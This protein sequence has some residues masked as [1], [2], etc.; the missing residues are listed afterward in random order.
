MIKF[1]RKI[2]QKLLSE[3]NTGKY[4]KYAIGEIVLVMVGILLALKVNN[5]N[6]NR[7]L[8]NTINNLYSI[9]KNDL[10]SDIMVIDEIVNYMETVDTIFEN[11]INKTMTFEN[12][13]NCKN[14]SSIIRG[15]PDIVLK[16][17][18]LKLL[19][20]NSSLFDIQKDSLNISINSFYSYYNAEIDVALDEMSK[21]F[22]NNY[23]YWKN[24]MPW[25]N[26]FYGL[27][28]N[29]T[30]KDDMI[31]YMLTSDYRN[32]VGSFYILHYNIYLEHIKEYTKDALKLIKSIDNI[33]K[34][35]KRTLF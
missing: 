31:N 26:T 5:W 19:Q 7:K 8:Q 10:Q 27:D 20:E 15:Y 2:R 14:C 25:F 13:K 16:K 3:G 33:V 32:R 6:E 28:S 21:D 22:N 12:Y 18:G 24:N 35:K 11:V 30:Y 17:R 4:L 23:V 9:I 29:P 34:F 1:F